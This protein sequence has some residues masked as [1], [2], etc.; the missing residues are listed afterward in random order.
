MFPSYRANQ[1]TG[2]RANQLTGFYMMET[3]VVKGL[4][5]Y[6][7]PQTQSFKFKHL[8]IFLIF[9]FLF[10]LSSNIRIHFFFSQKQSSKGKHSKKNSTFLF[11]SY[12]SFAVL[13][14]GCTNF[15]FKGDRKI[16]VILITW[17][18]LTLNMVGFFNFIN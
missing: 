12:D 7:L 13:Y 17:V 15:H 4:I 6:I 14:F 9:L 2:C 8:C 16:E 5:N 10:F 1:L 11:K 3:L 18:I